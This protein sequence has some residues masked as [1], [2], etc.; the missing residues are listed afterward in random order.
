MDILIAPD[1]FKGSLNALEVCKALEKGVKRNPNINNIFLCPLADGGD[2]SLDILNYYKDLKPN[3]VNVNDPLFRNIKSTYYSQNDIAYISLSSAS[4]LELLS[5]EERNCM[6]T[7]SFGTGELIYDAL[8]KGLNTINLFIGGSATN[9]G[10]IG[11]A[12]ALGYR[13]YDSSENLLSPIGKNLSKIKK[14]DKNNIKFDFEKTRIK[15]ICDVNNYLYGKNGAAYVYASQKGAN[16]SQIKELDKGLK[17]LE[18]ILI[19]HNFPKIGN[20]PGSGAAGGVGGGLVAF[21]DSKLISG[22]ETFIEISQ[23]ERKIKNCDLIITGEG[24]LDSQTRYG[25]VISG[26]C[27]LAKKYK[28][29]IIAVCGDSDIGIKKSLGI[30]KVYNILDNSDSFDS[31]IKNAEYYLSK[32]GKKIADNI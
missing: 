9:D 22:I 25:K 4:G 21:M 7:S 31:A 13:F 29:P 16:Y 14:I 12:S 8:T 11:I 18:S 26:I 15:V 17:N 6:I 10:A 1:K 3:Q 30:K 2:G 20:I 24:K 28:K 23:I 27:S 19:D 32:I 5:E